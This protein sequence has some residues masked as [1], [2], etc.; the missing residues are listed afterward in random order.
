VEDHSN[1]WRTHSAPF[2]F[3]VPLSYN[4]AS[5][6]MKKFSSPILLFVS[7]AALVIVLDQLTKQWVIE[8]V[9]PGTALSE[10][11]HLRI[12]HVQ[13]SGAA[14]GLFP[15]QALLLSIVEIIG[16]I[17][18]VAVYRRFASATISTVA[19]GL[20]LGGAIGNLVDR[21]RLGYV[22]DFIEFRFW[23]RIYWPTFNVADS[24]IS[25]GAVLLLTYVI[26]LASRIGKEDD[27]SDRTGS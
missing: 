4:V 13:N 9:A 1:K 24:G 17:F 5:R 25:V 7:I 21:L 11:W 20:V 14:F 23:D 27:Q 22:T 18:I 10:F 16:V 26:W 19:L 12:A 2:A 8:N 3:T 6:Q 15:N